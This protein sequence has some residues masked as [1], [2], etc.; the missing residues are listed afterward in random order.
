MLKGIDIS[1]TVEFVSNSDT[2]EDKTKFYIGN[3]SNRDKLKIFTG[4]M[5]PDGSMNQEKLQDKTFDILKAGIK[6]ITN[7]GGKDYTEITDDVLNTLQF[8]VMVEL[9]GK[10]LEC[11]FLGEAETKN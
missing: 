10:I 5:N 3:I 2:G 9:T 1:E 7:L 11:N 8:S 4:A 6:K